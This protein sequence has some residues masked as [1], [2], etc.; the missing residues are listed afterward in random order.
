M[1]DEEIVRQ[2]RAATYPGDNSL[3]AAAADALER[4]TRDNEWLRKCLTVADLQKCPRGVS[5]FG[6]RRLQDEQ[7]PWVAKN[8]GVEG[9]RRWQHPFMGVVEEVGELSHAL[10]KQEQGI[11][12]T[13]AE[14][15]EAAQDAVG[16]I[17]V[18]LADLCTSRGWS[19]AD[20]VETVW[21]QVKQRDWTKDPQ[22]GCSALA[23]EDDH[24]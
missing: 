19:F 7:K 21:A 20:I 11:R 4:L 1:T 22:E 16:D 6:L 17:V 8:F 15:E 23:R 2:L 18:Y 13:R 5:D 24:D 10:L 3:R 14:H 12:G 9:R